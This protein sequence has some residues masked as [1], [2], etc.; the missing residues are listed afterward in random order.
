MRTTISLFALTLFAS[1]SVTSRLH[2]HESAAQLSQLTK[3]ER[4]MQTEQQTPMILSSER[5]GKRFFVAPTETI[6]GE[7]VMSLQMEQVTVVSKL[8]TIPE[9]GGEIT[10]DFVVSIPKEL[11]GSS[12]NVTITPEL[13]NDEGAK[14]L[15]PLTIRGALVDKI[16]RRDY[17]QYET[18]LSRYS[19][20][21]E[22]AQRMYSRFVKFP[23]P[24]DSR[25]DSLID[26][27]SHITYY[28]SQNLRTDEQTKRLKITL[29]GRVEGVDDTIYN[30]PPS[31]T[32]TYTISSMLSFLDTAPRF[33][34]KI[35][36]KYITVNDRSYIRY[37]LGRCEIV[38]T[39]GENFSELKK[40]RKLM[41]EITEQDEFF[42]DTIT[43]TATSSPE[44]SH[45]LNKRLSE[46]RA[47]ALKNYL[48]R[49]VEQMITV[50]WI[51]ED[52]VRLRELIAE[53]EGLAHRQQI[54]KIIDT[55]SNL[56]RREVK[57]W[58]S[59]PLD[60]AIIKRELYPQLRAVDFKYNLRRKGMVKDTIQ[61]TELD[62]TY[63]RGVRFLQQRNYPQA[64]YILN[65]YRDRNTI[66]AHLSMAHDN[67]AL[68]LLDEQPTTATTNYLRAIAL[69]R[70]GR[71]EEAIE[72][73]DEACEL[74]PRMK[75]RA[76]LDP[77]ITKLLEQ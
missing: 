77:E 2:R 39:L 48:G 56:D 35:V 55:E 1:C 26:N 41:R 69:A 12:R 63:A 50:K 30:M 19:P 73:F 10:L 58:S 11:L 28:Y 14:A 75:F 43:L 66:I 68:R 18:Y 33:R 7:Q 5:E 76:N 32:L 13:H 21:E 60:Y 72:A 38:D 57:I 17:W 64:L 20:T 52:W 74:E 54:L 22:V 9:R 15:E 40:I 53:N 46:R 70:L 61:T 36:D 47:V 31:D 23:R 34:V 25:L 44:G 51:A 6:D 62:T 49:E 65:E 37:P 4:E 67:E 59:Y 16:Q 42:V 27:R 24:E 71:K 29:N 3:V 8:R 45:A